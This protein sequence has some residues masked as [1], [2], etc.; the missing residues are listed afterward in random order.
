MQ[1]EFGYG[2]DVLTVD[3]PEK[4]LMAMLEPNH[5]TH[6]LRAKEA[7]RYVLAHLMG[8]KTLLRKLVRLCCAMPT[9]IQ[10][11]TAFCL[12]HRGQGRL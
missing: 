10:Q 11:N 3:L 2:Q 1:P 8:E 12:A 6:E 9:A 5:T 7:L 4:K